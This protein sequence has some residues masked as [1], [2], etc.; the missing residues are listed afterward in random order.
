MDAI[1]SR[2]ADNKTAGTAPRTEAESRTPRQPI[3]LFALIAAV[4]TFVMMRDQVMAV[5]QTGG[6]IDTDDAMHMV[7]V[8]ALL[9]GQNW[10]DMT[11]PR[12]GPPLGTFMHWSRL[13]DA[14]VA[15]LIELFRLATDGDTAERLARLAFP[16]ALLAALY[17][18]MARLAAGLLGPEARLPAMVATM[19]SGSGIIQFL[20]GRID[21]HAPQIVILVVILGSAVAALDNPRVRQAAVAGLLSGVS[22]AINLENLPFLVVVGMGFVAHWICTGEPARRTLG[23]YAGGLLVGLPAFFVMTV[24]PSHYLSPVCDAY[25][26]AHLGAG[27]L[28]AAGLAC[29]ALAP[30]RLGTRLRRALVAVAIA[31]AAFA[32]VGLAY[33]SCLRSPFADVD[34]LVREI[35]LSRVAESLPFLTLAHNDA[36]TAVFS[37]VPVAMGLAG[38]LVAACRGPSARRASFALTSAVVAGGLAMAFWQVRVFSTVTAIALCG[39]LFAAQAARCYWQR[40]KRDTLA[41]LSLALIVPFTATAVSVALPSQAAGEADAPPPK[42]TSAQCLAPAAFKPLEPLKGAVIAPVD[43]GSFLLVHTDLDVFAAAFHRDND[44]NRFALD[45]M[46]APAAEAGRLA[47][48]RTPPPGRGRGAPGSP[49]AARTDGADAL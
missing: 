25:G 1:P 19:L 12:M 20:P 4:L 46:L 33:P 44:G 24:G 18:A 23:W 6:Y 14:P 32:F 10:F 41:S 39:G 40:R 49:G 36:G 45:T 30:M 48:R 13:V 7:Q 28:A 26:A 47:A 8:R 15:A 22:L 34:P 2:K 17:L 42:V 11:V 29:A 5:W 9:G 37:I 31:G 3:G 16:F 21:H 27:M 43:A 38:C 35:W